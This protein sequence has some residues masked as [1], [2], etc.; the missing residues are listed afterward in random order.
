MRARELVQRLY[1]S[2]KE[3]GIGTARLDAEVLAA[4]SLGMD[5]FRLIANPDIPCPDASV[6]TAVELAERRLRGEPVAYCVGYKE[7]YS[8][9]FFVDRRVLVPR[10]ETELLVDMAIYYAPRD[11]FLLDLCTGSGAIA[12]AVKHNRK[13]LRVV[14]ADI[15]AEALEVASLNVRNILGAG[16]IDLR[17]GDLFDAVRDERFDVIVSNPPYI[18]PAARD[19]LQREV[20]GEPA[21][22]LFAEDGGRAVIGRIIGECAGL[23][24]PNGVVILEMG[25]TMTNYVKERGEKAG[26]TVSVLNDYAGLARVAILKR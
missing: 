5:R 8:L 4:H 19:T 7:F 13:D 25:E 10:P 22:A 16:E 24:A 21:V 20:L 9:E 2:F 1:G 26:F 12:V 18:D 11:G 6:S 23:L 3:A 14:A 17:Q 15:S